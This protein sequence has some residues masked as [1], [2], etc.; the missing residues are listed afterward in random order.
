MNALHIRPVASS[1]AAAL[2]A[3]E[4][5]HRAFFERWVSGRDPAFY[6]LE[7]VAAAMVAAEAARAAG[8]AF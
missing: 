4:L 3:F 7:G 1:D 5:E 2:L 6:S 8:Q